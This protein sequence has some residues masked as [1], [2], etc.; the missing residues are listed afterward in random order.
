M[1]Q[2]FDLVAT[3]I[4]HAGVLDLQPESAPLER[5]RLREIEWQALTA[6]KCRQDHCTG[7]RRSVVVMEG[8]VATF[9][10]CGADKYDNAICVVDTRAF[11]A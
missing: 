2:W 5:E 8:T 3:P 10:A 1:I 4:V 9:P 6:P 11:A 7:T